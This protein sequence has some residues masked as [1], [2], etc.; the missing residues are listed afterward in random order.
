[1]V[2]IEVPGATFASPDPG[3]PG[4]RRGASNRALRLP[5]ADSSLVL[6]LTTTQFT[7]AAQWAVAALRRKMA[8]SVISDQRTRLGS[9]PRSSDLTHFLEDVTWQR[10]AIRGRG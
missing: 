2:E 4:W 9:L 3:Q 1:M 7:P 6:V 5:G 10:T 8:G